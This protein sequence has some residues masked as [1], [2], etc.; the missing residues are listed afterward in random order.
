MKYK[1]P[2]SLFFVGLISDFFFH[3]FFLSIPAIILLIIGIWVKPCLYVASALLL[4][5]IVLSL[6]ERL[7]IRKAMISKSPNPDFNKFQEAMNSPDWKKAVGDL[8]NCK[9]DLTK[10]DIDE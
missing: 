8:I 6:V 2:M 3:F 1:Y 9:T 4:L 10:H 5:D 7:R